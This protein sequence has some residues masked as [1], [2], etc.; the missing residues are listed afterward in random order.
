MY[1]NPRYVIEF[2]FLFAHKLTQILGNIQIN[3]VENILLHPSMIG[4]RYIIYP[5]TVELG[6]Y[7]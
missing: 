3:V 1:L 6:T 4:S 2:R 7:F 5:A